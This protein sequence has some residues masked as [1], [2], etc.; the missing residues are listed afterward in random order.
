MLKK[1][2][3]LLIV[4]TLYSAEITNIEVQQ[5]TDGSGIID[6]TYDLIDSEGIYPSFNVSIEMSIDGSEYTTLN[7]SDLSGDI[8]ENVIPGASRNIQI[9]APEDT[10]SDNVVVKIIASATIVTGELPFT[11]ISISSI[12]GVSSYQNETIDYNFQMMQYEM[13]NA[14]LVTFL[15]TYDFELNEDGERVYN[16]NDHT[17]YFNTGN[18]N[19]DGCEDCIYGCTEMGAANYNPNA[20]YHT[21]CIYDWEVG[22]TDSNANNY[23]D[24]VIYDNCSCFNTYS[25]EQGDVYSW[26]TMPG[27]NWTELQ[28]SLEAQDLASYFSEWFTYLNNQK[29][30]INLCDD[31]NAQNFPWEIEESILNY[32]NLITGGNADNSCWSFTGFDSCIYEDDCDMSYLDPPNGDSDTDYGTA[33]I[34]DFNTHDISYEGLSFVIESGQGA[35]PAIFNYNNCVD[36]V[37]IGLMLDYYGL[38][39][40]TGSEWTKAARQ[41]NNR[42]W[43]WMNTNC[44]IANETYCSSEYSC[45]TQEEFEA[46]EVMIQE[47]FNSCQTQCNDDMWDCQADCQ[48]SFEDTGGGNSES[49]ESCMNNPDN[50]SQCNMDP[51]SEGCPCCD[52]CSFGE[53]SGGGDMECFQGCDAT[54]CMLECGNTYG[55]SYSSCGGE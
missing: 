13:T 11:M 37:I 6:V 12:E 23:N 46:C 21:D 32:Q 17:E 45:L 14:D 35:K 36:G 55:D 33:N 19:S 42:C 4:T 3:L 27:C 31:A 30:E 44:D 43:P 26:V 2:I 39:L 52:D 16:C 51:C 22:C 54:E 29:L 50:W 20:N 38:R 5:R 10:Y 8:G 41:D 47:N 9:Q 15:E 34:S 53:G 49:C 48:D 1:I 7:A 18:N 25:P 28:D 40:P 24:E